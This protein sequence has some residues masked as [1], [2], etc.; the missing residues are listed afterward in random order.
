[1]SKFGFLLAVLLPLTLS[2]AHAQTAADPAGN[3]VTVTRIVDNEQTRV[4]QV[5]IR[6]NATRPMH[7]H[8][9]ALWHVFVTTDAPIDLLIEGAPT[10]HLGPWQAYFFKGGTMHAFSNP[11][12]RPARWIELFALKTGNPVALDESAA[13]ALALALA[14]R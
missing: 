1:M 13:R 2:S 9:E 12:A 8:P 4:S 3:P 6:A 14:G 7:S 11:N 10:V 5:V